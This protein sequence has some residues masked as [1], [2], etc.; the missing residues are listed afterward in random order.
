[1]IGQSIF[2]SNDTPL[3]VQT[4]NDGATITWSR[5]AICKYAPVLLSAT[6]G[7]LYRGDMTFACLMAS[8]F[9]LTSA[10]AWKSI[11]SNGF[12]DTT[13]DPSK[14]RMAQ[15]TAAWGSAPPYNVMISEDGFLLTPVIATENI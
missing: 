7:T 14:V 1:M 12:A 8:D 2:G 4:I 9:N 6:Q 13:F 11:A 3:V 10:T 5:G 15:Y